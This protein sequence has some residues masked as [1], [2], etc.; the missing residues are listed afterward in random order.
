MYGLKK[1]SQGNEPFY[2]RH[3]S[4]DSHSKKIFQSKD[5]LEN[6]HYHRHV[7]LLKQ[8]ALQRNV[9]VS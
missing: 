4:K 6:H 1:K 3:S 7:S 5:P 8:K 9:N 2:S